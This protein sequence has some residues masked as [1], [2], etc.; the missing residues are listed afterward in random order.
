MTLDLTHFNRIAPAIF[1]VYDHSAP[2]GQISDADNN[3]QM[4]PQSLP[5]LRLALQATVPLYLR[6][7]DT[8]D[9]CPA[10]QTA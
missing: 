10:G 5:C 7:F 1:G 4:Q 9:A 2:H 3:R 6:L 8:V